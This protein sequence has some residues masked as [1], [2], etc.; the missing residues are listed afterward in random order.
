MVDFQERV[1]R[2]LPE[3][4]GFLELLWHFTAEFAPTGD[5][6]RYSDKRIEAAMGWNGRPGRL[7]EALINSSFICRHDEH[8][9]NVHDWSAHADES[10]K[11]RLQRS[12]Q[13]FVICQHYRDEMT[14]KCHSPRPTLSDS[15]SESVRL[16]VPVPKPEPVPEPAARAPRLAPDRPPPPPKEDIERVRASLVAFTQGSV[17]QSPDDAICCKL[18]RLAEGSAL[19]IEWWLSTKAMAGRKGSEIRSWG[20]FRQVGEAE[21]PTVQVPAEVTEMENRI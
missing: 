7:L 9:L 19:R 6:G 21:L 2:S 16:P 3:C 17:L 12:N 10:L 20:F 14:G 1:G 8:R 4:V 5:I 13:E 18:L 15:E 11:R